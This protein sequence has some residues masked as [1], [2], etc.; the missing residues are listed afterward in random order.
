MF[1]LREKHYRPSDY[2]VRTAISLFILITAVRISL[3]Q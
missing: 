3:T 2:L 1:M